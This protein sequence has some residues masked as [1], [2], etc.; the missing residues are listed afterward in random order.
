MRRSAWGPL[1]AGFAWLVISCGGG[2][3][4]G[5]AVGA[6]DTALLVARMT[7]AQDV[8]E[9]PLL[10]SGTALYADVRISLADDG[11]FSVL[12]S[13]AIDA[14]TGSPD[15]TLE[16]PIALRDLAGYALPVQL[17]L[18]RV[19]LDDEVYQTVGIELNRGRWKYLA[20]PMPAMALTT[21]DF[22][23]NSALFANEDHVVAMTSAPGQVEE[24]PLELE[25]RS[26]R[27][28]MDAQDEGADTVEL[29]DPAGAVV[30]SLS[31]GGQ[32]A[33]LDAQHGLYLVRQTYGGT[34]SS[35]TVFL[36]KLA[37][38]QAPGAPELQTTP[39]NEYWGIQAS[40]LDRK[41]HQVLDRPV[42]LAYNGP[43]AGGGCLGDVRA[44]VQPAAVT[45]LVDGGRTL[46]D[47]LN[48]FR[49]LRDANGT[50]NGIDQPVGCTQP[51]AFKLFQLA[52]SVIS[53]LVM[54]D[55]IR[56]FL[57]VVFESPIAFT[58]F[59]ASSN[60]F[61][62]KTAIPRGA[63][64]PFD[65]TDVT[66]G[67]PRDAGDGIEL[68]PLTGGQADAFV[69]EYRAVLRYRPDGFPGSSVPANGQVAL[70]N[71]DNCSGPALVLDQYD[72]PAMLPG[73]L[74]TF[75]RSVLLGMSTGA[76]V[77][78]QSVY[79]GASRHLITSGCIAPGSGFKP[80]SVR[81]Q[82]TTAEMVFSTKNCEACNLSG[83]DLRGKD[84]RNAKFAGSNLNGANLTGANLAGADLRQAFLQG[85]Q[86]P[87]ANL[88]AANL[89]GAKLNAAPSTAGSTN[90]AANLA[91]AFLRNANLSK[92]NIAGVNFNDTNFYS[93]NN[94]ACAPTAC[95]S[96]A[97]PI[98]ASAA[99]AT[100]E[101]AQFS[102]AYMVGADMTNMHGSGA[103]FSNAVLTG[104]WFNN[105]IL[106]PLNGTPVN[107]SG[108]F[109]Q[110]ADFTAA[111]LTQATFTN[112]YD[113]KVAGCMQ[114][115][116]GKQYISFPGFAVPVTP[117][118]TQC[119]NA[120]ADVASTC[121]KFTFTRRT[122]L[123]PTVVLGTPTVP[124]AQASPRNSDW[125]TQSPAP[126]CG[127]PFPSDRVNTC[128]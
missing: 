47:G 26:Y 31:A 97:K 33:A 93:S 86:L 38:P 77:Y 6:S 96:Y 46:F 118:S 79:R 35:R 122:I 104:A 76:N 61:G 37:P 14:A 123:P 42:F 125:C 108:A 71:S 88:D 124:L 41:T 39:P 23:A 45:T 90:V 101:G 102:N 3:D 44:V 58:N 18:R 95:D 111:D 110:G 48:F 57:T 10:Q 55:S 43:F 94:L 63:G 60:T 106:A 128:W 117:D 119:K 84:L 30:V 116:L 68:A 7:T 72:L 103:V 19:Q 20:A 120:A 107:F 80:A 25:T 40:L 83:M 17:T 5:P 99:G 59:T 105:A 66:L 2:R 70:F 78:E 56:G 8:L 13:R 62:L 126:L 113:A 74:G 100:A 65:G 92:S 114:F 91:G 27:F 34:G 51:G 109:I 49:P 75:N 115:E 29:L 9:L 82:G 12:S 28:C 64:T 22:R 127:A 4:S 32:C 1:L 50:A 24:F 36:H 53:T 89:C 69:V 85:A 67:R 81:I 121:V 16:P 15:A 52:G 11:T 54:S 98:C 73:P 112:A 87:N 21:Q